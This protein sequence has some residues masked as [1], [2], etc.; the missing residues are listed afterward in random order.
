MLRR[1]WVRVTIPPV[2]RDRL[3]AGHNGN[4]QRFSALQDAHCHPRGDQLRPDA[5]RRVVDVDSGR[6]QMHALEPACPGQL[7]EPR[8]IVNGI[9]VHPGHQN[10]LGAAR[11]DVLDQDASLGW[12]MVQECR[13][14]PKSPAPPRTKPLQCLAN[15]FA[16]TSGSLAT[17][18]RFRIEPSSFTTHTRGVLSLAS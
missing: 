14:R 13:K 4:P 3:P 10:A 18:S 8:G 11:A 5:Q 2:D 6:P 16:R 1:H 12:A 17:T 7:R 15:H 9:L